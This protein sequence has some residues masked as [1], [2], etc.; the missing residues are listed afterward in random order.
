MKVLLLVQEVITTQIYNFLSKFGWFFKAFAQ[1]LGG[2][3]FKNWSISFQ[4]FYADLKIASENVAAGVKKGWNQ[5]E[6]FQYYMVGA[7]KRSLFSSFVVEINPLFIT[8]DDPFQNFA[9]A[10][11]FELIGA[12][13]NMSALIYLSQ[14]LFK[15]WYLVHKFMWCIVQLI[16]VA[17]MSNFLP[18]SQ[19][20][21]Y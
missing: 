18:N 14:L 16:D 9:L 7:A 4:T 5:K 6:R 10:L 8:S 13:R 15:Q 3:E 12:G 21:E 20:V 11:M 19:V 17:L 1:K 2:H